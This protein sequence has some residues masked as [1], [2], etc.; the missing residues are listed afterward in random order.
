[1][2]PI[3]MLLPKT[4]LTILLLTFTGFSELSAFD[5]KELV[6]TVEKIAEIQQQLSKET[7]EWNSEK[8][9]LKLELSLL[10]STIKDFKG[11][12]EKLVK[13]INTLK[14]KKTELTITVAEQEKQLKNIN[15][16]VTKNGRFL[17]ATSKN[18]PLSLQFLVEDQL[19]YLENSLKSESVDIHE[20]LN[21]VRALTTAI[22]K[23]QKEIHITQEIITLNSNSLEVDAIYLGTFSGFF[24]SPDGTSFGKLTIQNGK[25]T[26]TEDASIKE[27]ISSLFDQFN[28]KGA[29]KVISLPIG[30]RTK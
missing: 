23:A 4:Y 2:S 7:A 17:T 26:A 15:N 3:F 11:D 24:Q 1:M 12:Q 13:K 5:R 25:W 28:K 18:I 22:L 9:S 19:A 29:P 16:F 27:S 6:K 10:K 8:E 20:K 21:A 30:G 14:Q